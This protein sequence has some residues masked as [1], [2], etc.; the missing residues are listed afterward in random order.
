VGAYS[1]RI[2]SAAPSPASRGSSAAGAIRAA[3]SLRGGDAIETRARNFTPP[4]V[5]VGN[6]F[7]PST[8]NCHCFPMGSPHA[9][10]GVPHE[11]TCTRAACR[12]ADRRRNARFGGASHGARRADFRSDRFGPHRGEGR[13]RRRSRIRPGWR[14]P[15]VWLEPR[16]EG[17]L[18]RPR[19]PSGTLAPRTVLIRRAAPLG[20]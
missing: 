18:A 5:G 20:G 11:K 12:L 1:D 14:Q 9:P 6:F 3:G 13:S 17:R 2:T 19:L 10:M 8:N 16:Q 7:R 4:V 15:R